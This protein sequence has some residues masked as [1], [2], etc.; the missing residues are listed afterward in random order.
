MLALAH[1]RDRQQIAAKNRCQKH[2]TSSDDKGSTELADDNAMNSSNVGVESRPDYSSQQSKKIKRDFQEEGSEMNFASKAAMI[3]AAARASLRTKFDHV[4][5]DPHSSIKASVRG[6]AE[7]R[8]RTNSPPPPSL[9]GIPIQNHVSV[10][11]F[12][13]H[14]AEANA[15]KHQINRIPSPILFASSTNELAQAHKSIEV[16]NLNGSQLQSSSLVDLS[17][18]VTPTYSMEMMLEAGMGPTNRHGVSGVGES[19]EAE[20]EH[21]RSSASNS[22]IDSESDDIS[23]DDSAS[24]R[25]DGSDSGTGHHEQFTAARVMALSRMHQQQRLQ[26]RVMIGLASLSQSES[27]R[28]PNDCEYQSGDSIDSM[29]AEDSGGSDSS[30]QSSDIA[31]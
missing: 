23:L 24:D 22:D 11:S 9:T 7:N 4:G 25:S 28:S 21:G 5:I 27:F 15:E 20:I 12:V 1:E 18:S 2:R 3:E 26:N 6:M 10:P 16:T 17:S 8:T 14:L 29:R 31:D 13:K 19:Q 30:S